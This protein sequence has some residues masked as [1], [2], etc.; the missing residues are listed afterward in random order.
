MCCTSNVRQIPW[1]MQKRYFKITGECGYH[2]DV[3]VGGPN[4]SISLRLCSEALI[5]HW[6]YSV[7]WNWIE[8]PNIF[9]LVLDIFRSSE[10]TLVGFCFRAAFCWVAENLTSVTVLPHL[11]QQVIEPGSAYVGL[12]APY[13][14][15]REKDDSCLPC[16]SCCA[17]SCDF[18]PLPQLW[19]MPGGIYS[20]KW[21]WKNVNF[22]NLCGTV[23][24]IMEVKLV[25]DIAEEPRWDGP[26]GH[27]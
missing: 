7:F 21:K 22:G 25:A 6:N 13:I 17:F 10:G 19:K 8:W 27:I 15:D 4:N 12:E 11:R 26:G 9:D 18:S 5:K 24:G 20:F 23:F 14:W 1:W 16:L 3:V 2:K